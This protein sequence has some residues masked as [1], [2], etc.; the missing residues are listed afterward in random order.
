M[1]KNEWKS[2]LLG[3]ILTWICNYVL[4]SVIIELV[5]TLQWQ[6]FC[7]PKS[8]MLS[9]H[10]RNLMD[11]RILFRLTLNLY[12]NL[13]SIFIPKLPIIRISKRILFGT[14]IGWVHP[15]CGDDLTKNHSDPGVD[16][17]MILS[18]EE[19]TPLHVYIHTL[20][21]AH[22][23]TLTYLFVLILMHYQQG[24]DIDSKGEQLQNS[25]PG[26]LE[27][28]LQ[29]TECLLTNRVH[30]PTAK[31][32]MITHSPLSLLKYQWL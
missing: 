10:T 14:V 22:I 4:K 25:N 30:K 13:L 6:P 5:Q 1:Q 23:N 28:N 8:C 17:D 20:T 3:F 18:G 2:S 19:L 24:S 21:Y 27:P 31:I 29:Q 7:N 32:T 26:S 9:K 11:L 16:P 12:Q 15:S